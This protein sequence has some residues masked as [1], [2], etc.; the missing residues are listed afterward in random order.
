LDDCLEFWL[1]APQGRV[2]ACQ[3]ASDLGGEVVSR[4]ASQQQAG[5]C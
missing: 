4:G 5:S 2:N 3:S 1:V